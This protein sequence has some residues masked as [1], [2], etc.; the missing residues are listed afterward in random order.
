MQATETCSVQCPYCWEIIETQIE[1]LNAPQQYIEDC[2][3]CCN[4]M[5]IK[6]SMDADNQPVAEAEREQD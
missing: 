4:P 1:P 5:L 2:S 3:V 6:I